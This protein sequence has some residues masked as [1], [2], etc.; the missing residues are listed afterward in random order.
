M[1]LLYNLGIIAYGIGIRTAAISR[2]SKAM[3]WV[4]GRKSWDNK[5][6]N[7]L[8]ENEQIWIHASS[9]GEYIMVKPLI[10][11]LLYQFILITLGL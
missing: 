7:E 6:K 5:L 1:K 4:D 10:E 2:H 9:L 11:L 8:A 3:K